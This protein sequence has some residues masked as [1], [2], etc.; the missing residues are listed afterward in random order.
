MSSLEE[1][2][3]APDFTAKDDQGNTVRLQDFRGKK[4]VVLYFYP[5]DDTPGCTIEACNFRDDY[6]RFQSAETQILGVSYDD[7]TSHQAFKKKF[8]LPFPLLVDADHKIAQMF[9]VQGDKYANRDTIVIAK[10][11]K[12]MKIIRKVDPKPH[13]QELLHLLGGE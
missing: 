9:G 11:G 2:Q 10:D 12:I 4:N 6:S 8:Q 1:G 7:A 13:S 5:K 3:A